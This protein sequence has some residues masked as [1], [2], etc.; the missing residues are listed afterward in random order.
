MVLELKLNEK[1]QMLLLE[2]LHTRLQR[3]EQIIEIFKKEDT[4]E[5]KLMVERYGNDYSDV[6]DMLTTLQRIVD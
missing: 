5:A 1:E 4:I 3:I 2:A 6:K